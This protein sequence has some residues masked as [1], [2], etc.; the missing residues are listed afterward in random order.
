LGALL[1]LLDMELPDLEV[2]VL[3][4]TELPDLVVP[5]L[6]PVTVPPALP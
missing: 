2:P 1:P 6:P 4:L 3:L 5:V